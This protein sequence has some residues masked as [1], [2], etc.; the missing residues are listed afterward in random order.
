MSIELK[1]LEI[2]AE[3]PTLPYSTIG[4]AVG[5]TRERVRQIAQRNGYPPRISIPKKICHVCGKTYY[6]RNLYCSSICRYKTKQ[7]RIVMNCHQCGKSIER[8][9]GNM[10]SKSGRYFCDRV[11]YTKWTGA[12]HSKKTKHRKLITGD[13]KHEIGTKDELPIKGRAPS[14][15]VMEIYNIMLQLNDNE[16]IKVKNSSRDQLRKLG[17]AIKQKAK[18]QGINVTSAIR[19]TNGDY[20]LFLKRMNV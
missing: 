8:T 7:K 19:E 16:I 9:P 12:N 4:E 17:T 20:L 15:E 14:P 13:F 11:C 6:T 10:R 2:L 5:V 18:R 1:V 3:N